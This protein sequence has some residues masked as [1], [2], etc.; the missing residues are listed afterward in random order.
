MRPRLALVALVGSA[1]ALAL[2]AGSATATSRAFVFFKSPSGN[3]G[4]A[5]NSA[6]ADQPASL[7]CDIRSGLRNPTVRRPAG[8]RESYG[9]SLAL[10][11]TGRP[12]LV[13]HGDTVFDP[14]A[15]VLAYG[16]VWSR[17]G[18]MCNS[19]TA[20]LRCTNRGGH[21]FFLSRERWSMF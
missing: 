10:R 7:R 19:R 2:V 4:C 18:F 20:G 9:D 8:C 1:L 14:A 17:G 13:C 3:I 16:Q 5:Y 15:R 11:K 12:W 6:F 21:G